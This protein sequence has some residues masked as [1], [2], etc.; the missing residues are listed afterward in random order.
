MTYETP[1]PF[2]ADALTLETLPTDR[3]QEVLSAYLDDALAPAAARHVTAWLDRHPD[4]LREVEHL[5]RTWDLLELYPD[6]EPPADFVPGVLERLGLGERRRVSPRVRFG[7][8]AAAAALLLALGIAFRGDRHDVST[9]EQATA[10]VLDD[11]P[12]DLLV[13]LDLLLSLTDEEF[14]GVLLDGPDAE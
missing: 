5:R 12:A 6:E 2:D 3:R 10:G 9:V 1:H 14:H 4:A 11:V 13:D 8:L 7:L